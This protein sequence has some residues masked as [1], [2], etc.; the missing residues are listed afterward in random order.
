MA[1]LSWVVK[2]VLQIL[3][4]GLFKDVLA[5]SE[6]EAKRQEEASKL[7]A[8]SAHDAAAVA[9]AIAQQQAKIEVDAAATKPPESD[10]YNNGAWNKE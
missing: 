2:F 1:I 7:N 10:P 3:L 5:R 8:Q 6:E 4:E 9:V